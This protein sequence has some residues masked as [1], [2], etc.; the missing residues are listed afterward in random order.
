M[1]SSTLLSKSENVNSVLFLIIEMSSSS[2]VLAV[3]LSDMALITLRYVSYMLN[4]L[5]LYHQSSY[6]QSLS[7]V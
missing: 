3:S 4:L 1:I 7:L 6:V 5:H 2:M